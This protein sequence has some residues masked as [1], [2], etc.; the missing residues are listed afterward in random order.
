MADPKRIPQLDGIRGL[1]I[2]QILLWHYIAILPSHSRTALS[3]LQHLLCLTW[4]GVDLFFVLSG[5][6]IGGILLD[7]KSAANYFT[8]FYARRFFR[9]LP[10]YFILL[11][12]GYFLNRL[13]QIEPSRTG[14][15]IP[16][17]WYLTFTQNFWLS[18]HVSFKFWLVQ[19]WSLAVEEQFYALLPIAIWCLPIKRVPHVLLAMIALAPII[20]ILLFLNLSNAQATTTA[21]TLLPCRMDTLLLGVFLAY[22]IRQPHVFEWLSLNCRV[23]NGGFFGLLVVAGVMIVKSW[24]YGSSFTTTV[25]YSVLAL[26]YSFLLL[27]AIIGKQAFIR[28]LTTLEPLQRLGILAYG[29]YLFHL[30]VPDYIF[31]YFGRNGI[32]LSRS[33][34]LLILLAAFFGVYAVAAVSWKVFEKP[35][36]KIGH[37]WDYRQESAA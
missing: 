33:S 36:L 12:I 17:Y 31:R 23:L 16:W 8:V 22:I 2:L 37:R 7:H 18:S 15:L 25:G 21:Y 10:L 1:A 30:L 11:S 19:S 28:R 27:I 9:I 14:E 3:Y 13:G 32:T 6:L 20:R 26:L 5:F 4:S 24:G 35:L 34:D 29:I